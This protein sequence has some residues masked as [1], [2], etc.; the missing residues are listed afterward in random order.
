MIRWE[1]GRVGAVRRTWPG[2][3]Q[4]TVEVRTDQGTEQLSAIS[5]TGLIGEVAVGDEVTLNTNALRRGLGTGGDAFVVSRFGV[6]DPGDVPEPAGHMM[7]ARYTPLQVMVDSVDDPSSEHAYRINDAEEIN[8]VP[9]VVADL[10]SAVPAI[11]AG[12]HV[13]RPDARIVYI[14]TDWAALPA[15]YSR[16]S[17]ALRSAGALEAVITCGQAFGGDLEAVSLP[18]AL[19]AAVHVL[20]ADAVIIAQG[21]GNLGTGTTW[22]FSG[23]H[24]AEA[25]NMAA[26][27]GGTV[28]HSA[29]VSESDERSRHRGLSHHSL[30]VLEKFTH[31]PVAVPVLDPTDPLF[32][33]IDADVCT[34]LRPLKHE[35][36][37]VQ[38]EGLLRALKESPV[39]LS[40]MGRSLADDPKAFLYPALAGR[41]AAALIPAPW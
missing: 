23:V 38:S 1:Q 28:I 39:R 22:G 30:T 34:A 36:H 20:E 17:A 11:V 33:Q 24:A 5:Y 7:K 9:V 3:Q 37:L 18:S 2:V 27:I 13:D 31:S 19:M 35:M 21:P 15:Q 14:H 10:H 16:A 32:R 8:G 26:A 4:L 40:S 6:T 41:Y 25:M 29:R 12:I